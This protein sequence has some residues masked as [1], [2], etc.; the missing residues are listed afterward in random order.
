MLVL[1]KQIQRV[2][3]FEDTNGLVSEIVAEVK[4]VNCKDL[5]NQAKA[6][7]KENY[8]K[9]CFGIDFNYIHNEQKLY[10]LGSEIGIYYV[11]NLGDKNYLKTSKI[12]VNN[13]ERQ[14]M[15]EYQKFLQNKDL[16]CK[17]NGTWY[18]IM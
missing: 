6:I 12:I 18:D 7:D 14:I 16:Y 2:T 13:L 8:S 15:Q 4:L 1:L 5:E 17:D 9:D 10:L 11:D 3:D